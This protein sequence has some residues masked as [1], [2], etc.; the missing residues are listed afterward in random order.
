MKK[1]IQFALLT[2]LISGFSIFS[3]K[4]FVSNMDPIVFTT[5]KNVL[6]AIILSVILARKQLRLSFQNISRK[7]WIR[8]V[9]I[10]IIGGGIPFALFFTGLKLATAPSAAIIHKTLFI[11]IALLAIPILR[12]RL[13]RVQILGYLTVLIGAAWVVGPKQLP[14]LGIGELMIFSATILWA[15]EHI[16]AKLVLKNV[17]SEIVSWMRMSVGSVLLFSIII[18]QGNGNV[19]FTLTASQYGAIVIAGLLLTGYV[20]SWYKALSYAPATLVSS[21]LVLSAPI[22]SMLTVLFITHTFPQTE[23]LSAILITIG[24][25]LTLFFAKKPK[26]VIL[27]A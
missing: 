17:P 21:I 16:I 18:W 13:S 22:T 24:I 11:W 23:I 14:Q 7:D 3:S 8:L 12:E 10:G 27:S 19:M 25:G 20:L 4:I 2:A 5:L 1:G 6:V 9:V 15:I 26:N